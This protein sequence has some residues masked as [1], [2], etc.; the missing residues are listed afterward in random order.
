MK[1]VA[2]IPARS[3]SKRLV[4]KNIK[5]LNGIPLIAYTIQA[6]KDSG[7][8][9]EIVV[10]TDNFEIGGI[11]VYHGAGYIERPAEYA[12]DTSPDVEWITHAL[13]T[14][15]KVGREYDAFAILRPTSPFRTGETIKR[16]F[17]EWDT[18]HCMKAVEKVKQHP[19]KMWRI[20]GIM[21]P[22]VD[23]RKNDH[24]L[25]NQI[26]EDIY[27]QN[28]SLEIRPV[29]VWNGNDAFYQP[30]ISAGREGYD[31]NTLE[32][33]ILAEELIKRKLAVLPEVKIC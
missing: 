14:L 2:L 31:I 11:G 12:T 29:K 6:A 17:S 16:A 4:N 3:G 9:D 33:W 26:L 20:N 19:S 10:S 23:G 8:F 5:K 27:V 18:V 24:L 21:F 25:P 22:Y 32:D 1:I 30:F 28:A 13:A 15:K 7:I